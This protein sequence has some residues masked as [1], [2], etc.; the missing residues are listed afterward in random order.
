M[1]VSHIGSKTGKNPRSYMWSRRHITTLLAAACLLF[2]LGSA[3]ISSG[4]SF[5]Q[6]IQ[7]PKSLEE[8]KPIAKTSVILERLG[9]FDYEDDTFSASL[10]ITSETISPAG[11]PLEGLELANSIRSSREI[12]TK[13]TTSKDGKTRIFRQR[14]SGTFYHPWNLKN[15]PFDRENLKIILR[16][17]DQTTGNFQQ[18]ANA[19]ESGIRRLPKILG[20]WKIAGF[21][22]QKINVD[23]SLSDELI[24]LGGVRPSA[25]E[26][27]LVFTV[28]LVNTH[29]KGALKLL[30]GGIIAAGITAIS[31]SLT[32]NI[33]SNPNSRFGA[34]TASLFA[35]VISMRSAYGYLGNIYDIT[36]IDK[37]YLLI[38]LYIFFAF[39][40]TSYLWRMNKDPDRSC[41]VQAYSYKAGVASTA[42]LVAAASTVTALAMTTN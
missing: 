11:N 8:S 34:L 19:A 40:C 31:Y 26:S 14:V 42:I 15:Y 38:L 23:H 30:S 21:Q 36:L 16:D 28:K 7:A 33:V 1:I 2:V 27:E 25:N 6:P 32:P 3:A 9:D 20:E 10:W 12:A 5:A 4:R 35:A 39:A 37:L 17:A 22:F 29:S 41:M 13:E 18:A 24:N